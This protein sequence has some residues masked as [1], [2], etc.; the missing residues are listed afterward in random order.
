M[1]GIA[2]FRAIG[3]ARA[4]EAVSEETN[5]FNDGFGR[6]ERR[7]ADGF[8]PARVL[9]VLEH[10]QV[11]EVV[12]CTHRARARMAGLAQAVQR[13]QGDADARSRAE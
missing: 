3:V 12:E 8:D 6:I 1:R 4:R 11:D 13:R 9:H 7:K 2:Q 10:E 5:L